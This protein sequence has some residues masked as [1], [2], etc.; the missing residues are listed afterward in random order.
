MGVTGMTC[1]IGIFDC[2]AR[3]GSLTS[4]TH[5]AITFPLGICG[6]EIL[7]VILRREWAGIWD[8]ARRMGSMLESMLLNGGTC[9][10][11]SRAL[12]SEG[13]W[14]L[15]SKDRLSAKWALRCS[16]CCTSPV[17]RTIGLMWAWRRVG[18]SAGGGEGWWWLPPTWP[19]MIV[20][21]K[22][23]GTGG[24][25]GKGV[26]DLQWVWHIPPDH[27]QV[28]KHFPWPIN[29]L[30]CQ[31]R[32]FSCVQEEQAG[33]LRWGNPKDYWQGQRWGLTGASYEVSINWKCCK[34]HQHC[35]QGQKRGWEHLQY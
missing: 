33:Q 4:G 22:S 11:L 23:S 10:A 3:R 32:V 5:S 29:E 6:V 21:A 30:T 26:L 34:P 8:L 31:K 7:G 16:A 15:D 9:W 35:W 27:K 17:L 20:S 13:G 18:V 12:V 14:R 25:G 19:W 2:T 24:G 1:V 28:N